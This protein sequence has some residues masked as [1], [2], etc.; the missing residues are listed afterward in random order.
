MLWNYLKLAGCS[1]DRCLCD[2]LEVTFSNLQAI[3]NPTLAVNEH[4][5][6]SLAQSQK[7]ARSQPGEVP[8]SSAEELEALVGDAVRKA[9]R[10]NGNHLGGLHTGNCA[11]C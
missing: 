1:I 2:N 11:C 10:R 5:V 4:E 7:R 3:S 9:R 6:T 8:M